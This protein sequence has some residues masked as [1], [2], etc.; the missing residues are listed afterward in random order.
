VRLNGTRVETTTGRVLL[1]E[2]VP[3]ELPFELINKVMNKRALAELFDHSYR[4]A[5]VKRT[6]ILADRIKDV[7]FEFATRSG[8]SIAVSD[9]IIPSSKPDIIQK[10]SD[11]IKEI[12]RQYS[13]G[14]ITDGEK[15]NKVVDIWAKATEDI[16]GEMMLEI[17]TEI[18]SL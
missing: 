3:S 5:G 8:L 10:A 12:E 14:L 7:G 2:V 18:P 15:Y 17:A 4:E 16:A 1:S 11:N 9:M 6:V 13:E